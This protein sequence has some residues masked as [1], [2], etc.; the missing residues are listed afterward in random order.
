MMHATGGTDK[1]LLFSLITT[2]WQ[3]HRE[4]L[5]AIRRKV[6][7]E[8]QG[9]PEALEWD[10]EDPTATHLLAI[11]LAGD[12]VGCARMLPDGR[13]GRMAVLPQY[14]GC[15]VGQ[16]LLES[17][18]E[19]FRE[20]CFESIRLSAQIHAVGFYEQAGFMAFGAVYDDAGIPHRDMV[21]K[22]SR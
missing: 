15:G 5:S 21:L 18:I 9:V 3:I 16:A 22:L 14:R 20:Q 12:P 10:D 2:D 6:F 11:S 1:T 17:A 4:M 13:L 7:I 8:E 19:W